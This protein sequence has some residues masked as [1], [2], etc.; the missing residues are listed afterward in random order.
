MKFKKLKNKYFEM[1]ENEDTTYQNLWDVGKALL[2]GKVI[3][4]NAY[5]K[6]EEKSEI[7]NLFFNLRTLEKNSK[8][9]I[10]KVEERKY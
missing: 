1:N 9:N 6:G 5:I 3:A 8:L 2:R 7:S 10:K 4:I